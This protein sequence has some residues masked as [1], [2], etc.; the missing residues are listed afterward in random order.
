MSRAAVLRVILLAA[1]CAAAG[2]ATKPASP[3][4]RAASRPA[5]RPT[6][7][8]ARVDPKFV[9]DFNA[10]L[11]NANFDDVVA[12]LRA[13]GVVGQEPLVV[14]DLGKGKSRRVNVSLGYTWEFSTYYFTVDGAGKISKFEFY[15]WL[16]GGGT[17]KG[18]PPGPDVVLRGEKPDDEFHKLKAGNKWYRIQLWT[19]PV[20]GYFGFAR[21]PKNHVQAASPAEAVA[22]TVE[23]CRKLDEVTAK[24]I[25]KLGKPNPFHPVKAEEI[26]VH[27]WFMPRLPMARGERVD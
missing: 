26:E 22:K 10:H 18:W 19:Q 11:V 12:K 13:M 23:A 9:E 27:E 14:S 6:T 25:A 15:G 16:D 20:P 8:P 5:S 3:P 2:P 4:A 17:I 7:E 1:A 21:V 24:R